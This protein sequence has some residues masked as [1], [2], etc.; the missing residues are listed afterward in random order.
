MKTKLLLAGLCVATAVIATEPDHWLTEIYLKATKQQIL[1]FVDGDKD[2]IAVLLFG[3]GATF[4]AM[5][6][7]CTIQVIT[8]LETVQVSKDLATTNVVAAG[9]KTLVRITSTDA[10][11]ARRM[12]NRIARLEVESLFPNKIHVEYH[13]DQRDANNLLRGGTVFDL[14][15]DATVTP[16]PAE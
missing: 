6:N 7:A 14:I 10:V 4:D 5:T 16:E 3:D 9:E 13:L 1:S 12:E 15:W 11:T 8:N 2:Q